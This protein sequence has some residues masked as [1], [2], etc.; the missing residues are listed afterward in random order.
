M[1]SVRSTPFAAASVVAVAVWAAVR[2]MRTSTPSPST[3]SAG[4]GCAGGP[5]PAGKI[6]RVSRG[7]WQARMQPIRPDPMIPRTGM[8]TNHSGPDHGCVRRATLERDN[9]PGN[10]RPVPVAGSGGDQIP[11]GILGAAQQFAGDASFTGKPHM[12]GGSPQHRDAGTASGPE[13]PS[14]RPPDSGRPG[15]VR[16][17][18][19]RSPEA[20]CARPGRDLDDA[21]GHSSGIRPARRG[22]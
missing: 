12:H 6:I 7:C 8:R 4:R 2:G 1:F 22:G 15:A 11:A 19:R 10:S 14:R 21:R 20:R 17:G 9:Q 3:R 18:M 5:G 16:A 13:E